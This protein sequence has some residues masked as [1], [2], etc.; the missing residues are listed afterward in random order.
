MSIEDI[1]Q[2]LISL[3]KENQLI[4]AEMLMQSLD[5]G[6]S[7]EVQKSHLEE[8]NNR[9]ADTDYSNWV[10]AKDMISQMRSTL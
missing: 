5:S 10:D 8:V 4:L 6:M 2:E 7:A 1:Y 9:M 3:P